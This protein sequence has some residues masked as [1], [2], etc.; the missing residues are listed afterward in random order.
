MAAPSVVANSDLGFLCCGI[1]CAVGY[2]AGA[3]PVTVAIIGPDNLA[4]G[5]HVLWYVE[6]MTKAVF[7]EA[8]GLVWVLESELA[9]L[10]V[11]FC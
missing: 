3:Y 10:A 9:F 2:F 5:L 8:I 7:D 11:A 1:L 4:Y 6:A